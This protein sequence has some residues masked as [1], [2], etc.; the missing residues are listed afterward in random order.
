MADRVGIAMVGCG[1]IANA[2]LKAVDALGGARLVHTMDVGAEAARAAAEAW[3]AARWSTAYDDVLADPSVDAVVLCLPHDLHRDHT[4]RAAQ[5]GKHVLVEKPM[6]MDEAEARE[7]VAAAET[8][9]VRLSVGQ[10]TRCFPAYQ[11][12]KALLEDGRIGRVLNV[13]HQRTFWIERVSTAWRRDVSACGGLYLPLFGSHDIDAML[14][15]L[16]DAPGRV[17][18]SIRCASPVSD[19]DSDGFIGLDFADGKVASVAFAVRSRQARHEMVLVG[20]EGTM[21]VLRNQLLLDGE[22]VEIPEAPEPFHL[23]MQR[24]VEALQAGEEVPAPGREV[25]RV[26]RTLDLVRESSR[27][28][29]T[30]DF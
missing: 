8:H 11:R 6:A 24:F 3:G 5:A 10:S 19:G 9:N 15:L 26:M 7:M 13:L 22:P 30:M 29:R 18:G 28:G 21:S 1:Q 23:Q 17:W 2:H 14:W 27:Q 25:V 16:D 12:A 4:I 20:T